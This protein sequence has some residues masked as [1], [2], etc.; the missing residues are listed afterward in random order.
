MKKHLV[1]LSVLVLASLVFAIPVLAA[2]SGVKGKL[3]DGSDESEAWA[4]GAHVYAAGCDAFGNLNGLLYGEQ[5]LTPPDSEF[6]FAWG[7]GG[8]SYDP[9]PLSGDY[10]CI[11]VVWGSGPS[12]QP[13]DT[14]T[15]PLQVIGFL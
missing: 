15:A 7:D 4:Y 14:Q 8:G 3:W 13:T 11:Y 2:Q 12:G 5:V 10:V 1:L 6:D 9:A